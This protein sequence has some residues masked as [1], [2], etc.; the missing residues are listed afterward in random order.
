MDHEMRS[1][2][3]MNS[4]ARQ[5]LSCPY[6]NQRLTKCLVP[7]SPFTEWPSEFQYLCFN[8]ECRYF[9]EGWDNSATQQFHGSYRFMYDPTLDSCF[10]IPVLN[11]WSLKDSIVED[12]R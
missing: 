6:C 2:Q 10:P 5:T 12:K 9:L 4:H 11:H 3:D 7:D 1:P 8:D